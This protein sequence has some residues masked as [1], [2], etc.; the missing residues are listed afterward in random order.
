MH[1]LGMSSVALQDL[2][3]ATFN[4]FT[5]R[6]RPKPNN[7]LYPEYVG[8]YLRSPKFRNDMLAFSTMS[9]RASLNNSMISKLTIRYPDRSYQKKIAHIL[10]TL[11]DKIELNRQMNKNLEAM[12]QALFKSWFVDF[13]PVIDNALLAGN[14]IPDE[15]AER[16]ELRQAQLDSG[17][18]NTNSEINESYSQVSLSLLRNWAGFL[19]GGDWKA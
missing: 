11:D 5:K 4:G 15:L 6:L 18:A 7:E 9:T 19:K 13:D 3:K 2:E 17:K 12:A 10:K 1:E 14:D 16:A 8:Y